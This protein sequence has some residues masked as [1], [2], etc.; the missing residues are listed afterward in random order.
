MNK[1]LG[2]FA[3]LVGS[4]AL[5]LTAEASMLYGANGS[6][7][8][9]DPTN[10]NSVVIDSGDS[11]YRLGLAYDSTT[12][13][14]YSAGLFDGILS[15][16]DLVTG[17]TTPVGPANGTQMTGLTFSSD[18]STLYAFD[19]NGGPLIAVDPTDG[20][21]VTIGATGFGGLDLS[22][23]S[24]GNVFAG[25]FGGIATINTATGAAM[26]IGGNL[27]WT[28]IAFDENDVLFGIEIGSDAL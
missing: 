19:F 5:A 21:A 12:G 3:T 17:D 14:M 10:G 15:T 25:G 4:L 11:A 22:T 18:F 24:S 16:V 20:S 23:D 1:L 27:A 6:L 28:A 8:Q 9:V 2:V 26:V 7:Y 13:T